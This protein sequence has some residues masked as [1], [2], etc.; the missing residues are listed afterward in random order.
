[1]AVWGGGT[2][3][4][5]A[6]SAHN[7]KGQNHAPGGRGDESPSNAHT[8]SDL[9]SSEDTRMGGPPRERTS[10]SGLTGNKTSHRMGGGLKKLPLVLVNIHHGRLDQL[11]I[12]GFAHFK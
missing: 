2:R 6:T 11:G 3:E 12:V 7:E 8:E 10:R 9:D 4:K 1:M 5:L